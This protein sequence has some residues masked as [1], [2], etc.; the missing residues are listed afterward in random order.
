MAKTIKGE[1]GDHA[2][3][4]AEAE[5]LFDASKTLE[6][7]P[8]GQLR[9]NPANPR[10]Y[11]F[12]F[13]TLVRRPE[14]TEALED[15][16]RF[17][18]QLERG[19][20]LGEL[21]ALPTRPTKRELL[22]FEKVRQVPDGRGKFLLIT[23]EVADFPFEHTGRPNP[24][25][26]PYPCEVKSMAVFTPP[27][28]LPTGDCLAPVVT[29]GRAMTCIGGYPRWHHRFKVGELCARPPISRNLV[30]QEVSC[31]NLSRRLPVT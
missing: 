9:D 22:R 26:L 11:G 12:K 24:H 17:R 3:I 14:A 10:G 30:R 27:P 18:K 8:R 31:A 4:S 15:L 23:D 16:E 7:F 6:R 29:T 2:T 13:A 25:P 5:A 19:I 28:Q 20:E 21:F 1:G